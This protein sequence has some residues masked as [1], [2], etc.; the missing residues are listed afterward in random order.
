MF[1][2]VAFHVTYFMFKVLAIIH[3]VTVFILNETV[4]ENN[5]QHMRLTL[6]FLITSSL[7]AGFILTFPICRLMTI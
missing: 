6:Q 2:Y 4:C 3:K 7:N 1:L 5:Y